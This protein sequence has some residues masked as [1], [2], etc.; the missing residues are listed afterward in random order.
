MV[1]NITKQNQWQNFATSTQ[2]AQ[3]EHL[4]W[5]QLI[6]GVLGLAAAQMRK[7]WIRLWTLCMENIEKHLKTKNKAKKPS[8]LLI[9]VVSK[10]HHYGLDDL[11][12][13]YLK[14]VSQW[15]PKSLK[16][17]IIWILL[18]YWTKMIIVIL[19]DP[20]YTNWI[21]AAQHALTFI[22][23]ITSAIYPLKAQQSITLMK[24]KWYSSHFQ[25]N[26]FLPHQ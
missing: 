22:W 8:Q 21:N 4:Q 20:D 12:L 17:I 2:L 23:P 3:N 25:T 18:N 14:L 26:P 1:W 7:S 19:F 10:T 16:S 5:P 15:E 13:L 9:T 6:R 11:K 24:C